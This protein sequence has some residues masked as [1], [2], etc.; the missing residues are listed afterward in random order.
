[1]RE[2]AI[3]NSHSQSQSPA[4]YLFNETGEQNSI[5]SRVH[6]SAQIFK[7]SLLY[8]AIVFS[9]GFVLGTIRVLWSVPRFG[10]RNAELLEQPLMLIAV[11]LAARWIV[12][13][14]G[15]VSRSV[16][17]FAIGLIALTLLVATELLVVLKL[18]GLSISE[19]IRTRDP[20]SRS[21]YF[22]MLAV[23][24]LGPWLL[25]RRQRGLTRETRERLTCC[26]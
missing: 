16:E 12:R 3:E 25:W 22:L 21:V 23:F 5:A 17:A 6:T 20:V 7:A 4:L 19:Y 2:S 11:F 9:T 18:R 13:R 14:A 15:A 8:F 1:M 24:A 26:Q 10:E